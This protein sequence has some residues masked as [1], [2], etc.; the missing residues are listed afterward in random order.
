LAQGDFIHVLAIGLW[1]REYKRG[2]I[3]AGFPRDKINYYRTVGVA[4]ASFIKFLTPGT[5]VVLKAS[6]YTNL[7]ILRLKYFHHS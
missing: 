4:E 2:A 6:P 3:Q 5:N 7:K 1:A